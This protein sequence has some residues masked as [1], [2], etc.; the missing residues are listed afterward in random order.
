MS[1]SGPE[2]IRNFHG[3]LSLCYGALLLMC[4]N[5]L[6]HSSEKVSL[7]YSSWLD[8]F[9]HRVIPL[10]EEDNRYLSWLGLKGTA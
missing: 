10:P 8:T 9:P 1:N 7:V 3:K 2:A 6:V 5:Y 4:S